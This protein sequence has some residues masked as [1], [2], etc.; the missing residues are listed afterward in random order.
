[1]KTKKPMA[2]SAKIS[3]YIAV[4]LRR[5]AGD[6]A[7]NDDRI[8]RPIRAR[9]GRVASVTVASVTSSSLRDGSQHGDR[10][11]TLTCIAHYLQVRI[12]RTTGGGLSPARICM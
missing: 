4:T 3:P 12:S 2:C 9:G 6:I 8:I 1:M 11:G 7:M 5:S 10:F